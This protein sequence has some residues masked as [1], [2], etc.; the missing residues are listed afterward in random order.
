M[1]GGGA[2]R[3]RFDGL[4]QCF[5]EGVDPLNDSLEVQGGQWQDGDA[6]TGQQQGIAANSG[7][8]EGDHSTVRGFGNELLDR[9]RQGKGGE[10]VHGSD[11]G[12]HG[13]QLVS[14]MDAVG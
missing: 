13:S 7:D 4:C 11:V 3:A 9:G 1:L 5:V 6:V 10:A 2:V 12:E 8:V 14:Q